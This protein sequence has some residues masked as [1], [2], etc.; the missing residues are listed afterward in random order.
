MEHAHSHELG[1]REYGKYRLGKKIGS[2]SFGASS[3]QL[4]ILEAHYILSPGDIYFGVNIRLATQVAIKLE[5]ANSRHR[6]LKYE[7]I[8]LQ[9][10]RWGY[11]RTYHSLVW[12]D[13]MRLQ[14]HG[15][16]S[17]RSVT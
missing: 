15:F 7:S 14:C 17:S 11:R 10:P 13:R 4:I 3:V 6:L 16:G 9:D 12:H 2:G 1:A 8:H 5:P